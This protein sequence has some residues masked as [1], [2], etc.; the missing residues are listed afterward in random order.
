MNH[1]T[2]KLAA[3][4]LAAAALAPNAASAVPTINQLQQASNAVEATFSNVFS[5]SAGVAG[6][7]ATLT[8]TINSSSG[9]VGVANTNVYQLNVALPSVAAGVDTTSNS[10]TLGA[11]TTISASMAANS[12][13][14][15]LMITGITPSGSVS[16]IELNTT[17]FGVSGLKATQ[18]VIDSVSTTLF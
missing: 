7:G 14:G 10:I 9:A 4:A 16:Q 11:I 15:V 1:P 17:V 5:Q 12:G 2:K 8:A 6:S 3:A 18:S 13:T